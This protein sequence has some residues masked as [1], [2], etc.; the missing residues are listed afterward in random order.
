MPLAEPIGR[1]VIAGL[2]G[3]MLTPRRIA[4]VVALLIVGLVPLHVIAQPK[5][6]LVRNVDEPAR[7][8]YYVS[9]PGNC[10]F[11]NECLMTGTTVPA[12][13]RLRVTRLEG[14]IFFQSSN[15]IAFLYANGGDP[16]FMFP[17]NAFGGA[18]Y[19]SV[20]SFNVEVDFYFEAGETPVLGVGTGI[21]NTISTDARNRYTIV[22]YLVDVLP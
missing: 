11:S 20:V 19:G 12:G 10:L 6:A 2:Q 17:S 13:Q 1:W 18:F 21:P 16:K 4:T 14:I 3:R 8:P 9:Q 5:P 7:V 15:I 22:G